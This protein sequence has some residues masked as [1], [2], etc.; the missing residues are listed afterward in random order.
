MDYIKKQYILGGKKVV[1]LKYYKLPAKL[2]KVAIKLW[3]NGWT[4]HPMGDMNFTCTLT[5]EGK[6]K[7]I[8]S[9]SADVSGELSKLLSIG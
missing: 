2:K 4:D 9:Q 1:D 3:R 6:L 8:I 5:K 7:K